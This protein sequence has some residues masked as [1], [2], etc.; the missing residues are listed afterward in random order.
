MVH[1]QMRNKGTQY[2]AICAPD[3]VSDPTLNHAYNLLFLD[4]TTPICVSKNRLASMDPTTYLY[5]WYVY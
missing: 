1:L 2:R 5:M 3:K 4:T